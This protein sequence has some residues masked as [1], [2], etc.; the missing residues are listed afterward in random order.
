MKSKGSLGAIILGIGKGKGK[1]PV[2]DDDDDD[3]GM[4]THEKLVTAMEDF[5]DAV[6]EKDAEAATDAFEALMDIYNLD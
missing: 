6:E 3:D 1:P 5:L 2:D 4:D